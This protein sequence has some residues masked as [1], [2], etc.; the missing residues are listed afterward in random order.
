MLKLVPFR[1]LRGRLIL[2]TCFATLPAFLFEVYVA[3]KEREAAL[4]RAETESRYAANLASREH[5]QQVQGAS[6]LLDQ[7]A[8]L[9]TNASSHTDLA[10]ML[11]IILSGFPQFANLGILSLEGELVYSVVPPPRH[12]NMATIHS[13]QDA[14]KSHDVA[15]GTYLVGFIVE[16]PILILTKAL[17]SSAGKPLQVLFAALDLAWFE[18][19]THQALLPPETALLIVDREG[20]ILASSISQSQTSR[21]NH[22]LQ[23]FEKLIKHQDKLIS[24]TTPDGVQRLAVATPLRGVKDVWV[25]VGP[26]A[27]EVYFLADGIFYRDLAVLVLLTLFAIGSLLIVT[28]VSVLRD[29]RRL[30][31]ATRSFGKGSLSARTAVPSPSGEIR[32][33]ALAFN[34][35]AT[36]LEDRHKHAIQTKERLRALSHRLQTVREQEAARIAQ[37]LHDELG[38]VLS[39]LRLELETLRRHATAECNCEPGDQLIQI[40]DGLGEQIDSAVNSVRRI[41]AELRPGVLDRLGLTA[42]LEWLLDEF[43]RRAGIVID[44]SSNLG[45]ERFDADLSTALFRITQEALTNIIRHSGASLVR[46]RLQRKGEAVTLELKDNGQ[47]FDAA[48]EHNSP[49]LGLL[50]MQERASRLGGT[51]EINSCQ[52]EGVSLRVCIPLSQD[53]KP[54]FKTFYRDTL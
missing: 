23:G 27:M 51:L 7:L 21:H 45:D 22:Q 19:L 11:P 25:V 36:A 49:S 34:T 9:T 39:V 43:E 38:Q 28:D 18:H 16:K 53:Q 54:V 12:I 33:L 4:H 50:G 2:L 48:S 32:D 30:A 6:H 46:V 42:G 17:R 26:P 13:F 44:F 35:M 8:G 10:K 29:L 41:S 1:T 37:E 24:C 5:S 47:G 15:V 31:A 14:L 3:E 40:I 52:G 20:N